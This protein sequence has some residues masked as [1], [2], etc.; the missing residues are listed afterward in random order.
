[1]AESEAH[2][3]NTLQV[4]LERIRALRRSI[5][6]L[7]DEWQTQF[8]TLENAVQHYATAKHRYRTLVITGSRCEEIASAF[9]Q[10]EGRLD[11]WFNELETRAPNDRM[12]KCR[13]VFEQVRRG[14]AEWSLDQVLQDVERLEDI[15]NDH[16]QM[17]RSTSP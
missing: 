13:A 15:I 4:L 1:M 12:A 11:E 9:E 17:D 6:R 10:I 3:V 14:E 2:A 16:D 8:E 5:P 7:H